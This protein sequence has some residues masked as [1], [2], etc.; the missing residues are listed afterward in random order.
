MRNKLA[1]IVYLGGICK[2]CGLKATSSNQSVFSFHHR[3]PSIKDVEIGMVANRSWSFIVR[4]LEKC[5]LL[6]LNCHSSF[7]S[8]RNEK[9]LIEEAMQYQGPNEEIKKM[10]RQLGL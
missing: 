2:H 10:L 8:T 5:D 9:T 6:C 1:A 4:E 7:H 3:D